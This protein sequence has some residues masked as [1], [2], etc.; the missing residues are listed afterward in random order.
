MKE[1]KLQAPAQKVI[2]H[3]VSTSVHVEKNCTLSIVG[4]DETEYYD[5]QPPGS[6]EVRNPLEEVSLCI[7]STIPL[8]F[9][10]Y[11]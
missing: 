3:S 9:I 10:M 11:Y 5:L 8:I 7:S 1:T 4:E 2:C 6:L